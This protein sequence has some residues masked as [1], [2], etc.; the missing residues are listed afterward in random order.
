[1]FVINTPFWILEIYIQFPYKVLWVWLYTPQKIH[2]PQVALNV[3]IFG[4]KVFS[5]VIKLKLGHEDGPNPTG[6]VFL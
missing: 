6:L 3:T 4:G 2:M 5:K 1:M